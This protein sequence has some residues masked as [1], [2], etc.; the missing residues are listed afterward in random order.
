MSSIANAYSSSG[1]LTRIVR[2]FPA[3]KIV[4]E[5]ITT[6][7]AADFVAAAPANV[8]RDD[9]AAAPAL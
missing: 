1:P 9:H 2:D 5:H 6:A 4:V 7:E 3:L 8:A